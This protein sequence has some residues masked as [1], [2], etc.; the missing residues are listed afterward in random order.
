MK[1]LFC[2]WGLHW[3]MKLGERLF[4]DIVSGKSVFD[5]TCP[6]GKHWMVDSTHGFPTFKVERNNHD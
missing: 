2:N 1:L 4:T 3:R 5:A 6:C